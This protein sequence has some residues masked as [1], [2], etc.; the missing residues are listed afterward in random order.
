MKWSG[1]HIHRKLLVRLLLA[2]LILTLL[3][4]GVVYFIE[5][6]RIDLYVGRL[7]TEEA[8]GFVEIMKNY[9]ASPGGGNRENMLQEGRRHIQMGHFVMVSLYDKNRQK[10]IEVHSAEDRAVEERIGWHEFTPSPGDAVHYEQFYGRGGQIYVLALIPLKTE[11]GAIIGYLSG[12]YKAAADTMAEIRE[13]IALSLLQVVIIVFITAL[14]VY[15]LVLSLNRGLIKLTAD[16]SH[17]NIGMLKVLGSTVAKRDSDTNL[18]NYRV[19][20]YAVRLAEA[21]GLK[22]TDIQALIKGA[23]LHDVGKIAISDNIL[24]KPGKL[25]EAE[26]AC[27]KKHV[28]HGIDIIGHYEWLEDAVPVVLYHHEKFD[29]TG[30]GM[31]LKGYDIPLQARIFAIA[32]VFDA[33]TSQRPYKAPDSFETAMRILQEGKG[34]HFDPDL[35]EEFNRIALPLHA[36]IGNAGGELLENILNGIID[37][38]FPERRRVF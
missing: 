37:F 9:I 30:Y 22:R 6:K 25:T 27:M 4:G 31:G 1:E 19:T 29:G 33:L 17:A 13:R 36:E 7:V 15:P 35:L 20:I 11:A 10:I 23:F 32:D 34:S 8:G 26:F 38:Y 28:S 5:I 24:L 14:A 16:L 21:L 18:H 3:I 2:W 12:V